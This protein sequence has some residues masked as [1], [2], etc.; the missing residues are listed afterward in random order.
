MRS[1]IVCV[2]TLLTSSLL[3]GQSDDFDK[4]VEKMRT[5]EIIDS[6]HLL[7]YEK[8]GEQF[9]QMSQQAK[10]LKEKRFWDKLLLEEYYSGNFLDPIDLERIARLMTKDYKNYLYAW[11]GERFVM[12]RAAGFLSDQLF[13]LGNNKTKLTEA[14]QK[15][16]EDEVQQLYVIEYHMDGYSQEMHRTSNRLSI[17]YNAWLKDRLKVAKSDQEKAKAYL[18]VARLAYLRDGEVKQI[19]EWAE[20]ARQLDANQDTYLFLA[21]LYKDLA[22]P[23]ED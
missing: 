18:A 9:E 10:F 11:Y 4:Y 19:M 6:L 1:I 20:K 22:A 16:F 21:M 12:N 8:G 7:S 13:N 3:I 15:I 5:K 14:V 17:N 2:I 23:K